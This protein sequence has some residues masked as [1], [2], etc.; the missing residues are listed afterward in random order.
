MQEHGL[1]KSQFGW[2]NKLGIYVG[3][4]GAS[5]MDETKI[6]IGRPRGGSVV[7]WKRSLNAKVI[8]VEL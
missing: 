3:K 7:H 6:L 1:Y 5:A 4:H 2:F 8:P